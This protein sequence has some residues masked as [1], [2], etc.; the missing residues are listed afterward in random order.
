MSDSHRHDNPLMHPTPSK[1]EHRAKP[2]TVAISQSNYIPWKGYFD[3]INS[4]D[5]FVLFDDMQYTRR[6]WRNR[7]R[8][9]TPQG[10]QWLSISVQT[11]GKYSQRICET[12]ISDPSW[13]ER[14][15]KTLRHCYSK[16]PHF[17]EYE[18]VFR[19]LYL[20][21]RETLLSRINHRFLTAIC[22][23]LGI[24]TTISWSMD[25]KIIEGKT[26]RLVEICRTAGA[27]TYL[28][29][30]AARTYIDLSMFQRAGITLAFFDYSGY[31]E[32]YQ[33]HPPFVH[34]VSIVDLIFNEGAA[35]KNYMKTFS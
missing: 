33:M 21:C 19:D 28:T 25:F 31:P 1:T 22:R 13:S 27:T 30:P 7:N 34:E 4:V 20:N 5:E 11:K 10:P 29:G 17:Q 26:E 14:H 6:D 32:Y 9:K 12:E 2:K 8:I 15:W 23:M 3:L 24:R 18:R 35:A 16:A